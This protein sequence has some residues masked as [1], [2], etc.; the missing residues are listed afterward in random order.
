MPECA[1]RRIINFNILID[2]GI[3][4]TAIRVVST[5]KT[6]AASLDVN[7]MRPFPSVEWPS[8]RP[9]L[10]DACIA[11][12]SNRIALPTLFS[13]QSA[14]IKVG[15]RGGRFSTPDVAETIWSPRVKCNA[16]WFIKRHY[17]VTRDPNPI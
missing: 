6:G 13:A 12:I 14:G 4:G 16:R 10:G 11:P 5:N 15:R 7:R 3:A 8:L 9:L 17:S 1:H 2:R